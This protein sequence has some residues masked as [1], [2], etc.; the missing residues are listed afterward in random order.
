MNNILTLSNAII[1]I[2]SSDNYLL[3]KDL[4]KNYN[5][6]ATEKRV[7]EMLNNYARLQY[8]Y[9]NIIPP[10]ITSNYQ[11]RYESFGNV[12]TVDKISYYVQKK[13]DTELEVKEF[14]DE[15][16]KVLYRMT[17]EELIYF[18]DRLINYISEEL[19]ADKLQVSRK[20]LK[21]YKESVTTQTLK[22][23]KSSKK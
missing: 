13:F 4:R 7:V 5:I 23:L 11:I 12:N 16:A 21:K 20:G 18:N 10:K 6:E 19:I 15:I 9:L 22:K 2:D 3:S 14:Y 1:N 8:K 17:R